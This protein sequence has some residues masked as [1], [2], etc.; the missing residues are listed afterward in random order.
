MLLGD[1][2]LET[3]VETE[4]RCPALRAP[5]WSSTSCAQVSIRLRSHQ[6]GHAVPTLPGS[7][8]RRDFACCPANACVPDWCRSAAL[9]DIPQALPAE[10]CARMVADGVS[11]RRS[12]VDCQDN[13]IE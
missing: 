3:K 12:W 1:A 5:S 9:R 10:T 8:Y 11:T 13:I 2:G 7:L 4:N 6:A